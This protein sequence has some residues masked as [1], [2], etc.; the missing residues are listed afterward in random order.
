MLLLFWLSLFLL[1]YVYAGY[2]VLAWL[3]AVVA[4]RPYRREPVEPTVT[5]VV[6]AYNEAEQIAGRIENLLELDYPRDKLDVVIAS[7][8]STDATV[9]I[10]RRY[11]CPRVIVRAFPTR[12]GKA[13][14]LNDVVPSVRGKIVLLADARQRFDLDAV[15]ALVA[16]FADPRVGAVSGELMMAPN[17]SSAGFGKGVGC[18]WRYEK[19]IRRNES[20]ANATVGAT[21]AIYAIR[22]ALF[23]RIP[24]D[25]ILD[26]VVIPLRIIREGYR[27]VFEPSARA[28]DATSATPRHEFVRKVRTIA[29]TFQ[30]LARETWLFDPER[31][32]LWIET[33]SHKALRLTTPLLQLGVFV[34]NVALADSEPYVVLLA[35]Q[36][37]FYVAAAAG[38]TRRWA[39]RSTFIVTV[40][41][42]ICVLSS[43]TVIGFVQFITRRQKATWERATEGDVVVGR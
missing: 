10:A 36:V 29:G 1:A 41:Y 35:A 11:E 6:A 21:G 30:L 43:A 4:P 25:T 5:V 7:D 13:A 16:G 18:Y 12:R 40:P 34:A 38:H 15:R 14:V 3:R 42:T 24:E 28:Y 23:E 27:V 31:N 2:P 20:R 8:G 22:R 17:P 9:E 26:D 37:L 32:P 39:R 19:F 33:I